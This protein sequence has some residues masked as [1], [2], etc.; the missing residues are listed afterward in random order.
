MT[1]RV[2]A[3]FPEVD[4]AA[5]EGFRARWD[6]LAAV[7]PAHI[8]VAFPFG[9]DRPAS[10]L[11]DALEPVLTAC[12]AFALALTTPVVW[13]DEYLFLLVGDGHE[14]VTRLHEAIYRQVLPEAQRPSDFVPHMTIGRQAHPKA[15]RAAMHDAADLDLPLVGRALSLTVYRRQD[16]GTRIRELDMPLGSVS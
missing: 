7:V 1:V 5:V 14:Q 8:T 16:D 12:P 10:A 4:T 9:W 3:I 15:M 2:V 11:A 13:E 6:P